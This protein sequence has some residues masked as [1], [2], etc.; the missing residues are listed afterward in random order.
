V[1]AIVVPPALRVPVKLKVCTPAT[2]VRVTFW[3]VTVPVTEADPLLQSDEAPP[4]CCGG[5]E[6]E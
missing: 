2:I 3:P 5:N 6:I 4:C 1:P